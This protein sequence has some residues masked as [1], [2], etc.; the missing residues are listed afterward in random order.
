[1]PSDN[2]KES[3]AK[4]KGMPVPKG[5]GPMV[6]LLFFSTAMLILPLLTYFSIRKYIVDSTTYGA[7]GAI[8]VVQLIVALYIYKAWSDENSEHEAQ[9]KE[10]NL[11]HLKQHLKS[12][13]KEDKKRA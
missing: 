10:K 3:R 13:H 9:M 12:G 2:N 1:M 7:M 6:T 5:F 11:K 8:V 4:P